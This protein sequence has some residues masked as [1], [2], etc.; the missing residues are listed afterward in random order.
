MIDIISRE[1]W[2]ARPPR[3]VTPLRVKP[4]VEDFVVHVHYLGG[5]RARPNFGIGDHQKIL[6][7]QGYH[8]GSKGWSDIA[9]SFLVGQDAKAYEGRGLGVWGAHTED[10]NHNTMA[11]CFMLDVGEVPT[12][13]MFRTASYLFEH[14]REAG[15]GTKNIYVNPHNARKKTACPGPV[16]T[17]WAKNYVH[18]NDFPWK[19]P[20]PQPASP[21]LEERLGLLE[22]EVA[23]LKAGLDA[24]KVSNGMTPDEARAIFRNEL[25]RLVA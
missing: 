7:T 17:D 25:R 8:M 13:D 2:G 10:W 12:D 14:M 6:Q 1:A 4:G 5:P 21:S 22:I 15:Y 20:A 24:V 18:A 16:V 23:N 9:Y 3:D 11:V 19:L